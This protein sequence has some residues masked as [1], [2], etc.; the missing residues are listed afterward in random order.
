MIHQILFN[1]PQ[2]D[3][4]RMAAPGRTL[5]LPWGRGVGKS[6][7]QREQWYELVAQHDGKVRA[8]K[9]GTPLRGIRI[10][11]LM[12]TFKHCV[13]VHA[14]EM[15]KEL[16]GEWSYLGGVVNKSRWR[17]SFPG[18]SW[19]QFFG[20]REANSARGLR[21]DVVTVDEADDVE[22]GDYSSVVKP[23][24][25]EPWSLKMR[26]VSGTPRRGRY[27]LLYESHN[28]GLKGIARHFTRHATCFEATN[29]DRAYIEND[30]R[31]T[32]TPEIF[33]REYLCDFDAAEALV[34]G[35]FKEDFHV[36]APPAGTKFTEV[37][38]G[39]DHG[40]E[41]PNV[42]LPIG[43]VGNGRDT[44]CYVLDEIYVQHT[45]PTE[46]K[47][48]AKKLV[49]RFGAGKWFADPSRPDSIAEYQNA[50]LSVFAANNAIDDGV[51]SVADRFA[52]RAE[53]DGSNP[54]AHLFVHPRCKNTIRELGSYRRKRDP[55]DADRVLDAIEDKNNHCLVGDTL[56]RTARG[57][58]PIRDVRVG[59][60]V[61][62]RSGWRAVTFS[63]Q[64][65]ASRDTY[66]LTTSN[67]SSVEG[68]PDHKIW[69]SNRGWIR[70]D[71]LR[72]GDKLA[73]WENMASAR[74]SGATGTQGASPVRVLAVSPTGTR[75]AVYDL[76]V[77]G[78]HEFFANGILVHNSMDALRYA[79]FTRFG[80]PL[81][82]RDSSGMAPLQ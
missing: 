52:I 81:V 73:A 46:N 60:Q 50:G 12:P 41:D 5:V 10:V 35:M 4:H 71:A 65:F 53:R 15:R 58:V 55:R 33:K 31:P 17:V 54:R 45:T 7:F 6:W 69:T 77:D 79:I 27:G 24:F 39:I 63:G 74:P 1:V 76:T 48:N 29:V 9:P 70:M 62:T 61:M 80:G 30:V 14:E 3:I 13:D 8:G 19:I 57:E 42:F 32:T 18:G 64:T 26:Y 25:T 78:A 49:G 28:F 2:A 72:Y 68:T 16:E 23:W 21:C 67:G 44:V 11:L 36:R 20:A 22:P 59:D 43:V 47:V 51:L 37:I 34:Y 38:Y 56:V 75:E 66:R 40:Y 82:P